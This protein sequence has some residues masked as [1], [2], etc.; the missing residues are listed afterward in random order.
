MAKLFTLEDR[1]DVI[2]GST[3]L[4]GAK[5]TQPADK[6]GLINVV[7]DFQWT[8]APRTARKDV[9]YMTLVERRITNNVLIQQA[10]Y[11]ISA[12][13]EEGSNLANTSY[14]LLKNVLNVEESDIEEDN[15][16]DRINKIR[17]LYNKNV[18]SPYSGL[19]DLDD[20]GWQ[21]VLPYF[22]N[23]NHSIRNSWGDPKE[24]GLLGGLIDTG[25]NTI[26]GVASDLNS[27]MSALG[28]ITGS[29]APQRV[30]TYI[31]RA[32]QYKFEGN[33]PTYSVQF[34][35]FN[36]VELEDVVNNWQL[37]FLLIYNTLPNRRSKTT[38]DPP[39][40]YE[41]EIPG[42][43]KSPATFINS[44]KVEFLGN[45]RI[46]DLDLTGVLGSNNTGASKFR[47]I[48]PDAYSITI[49]FEDVLPESKNFMNAMID[50]N[51]NVSVE[52][53]SPEREKYDLDSTFTKAEANDITY[54]SLSNTDRPAMSRSTQDNVFNQAVSKAG[55][56]VDKV[57]STISKPFTNRGTL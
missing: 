23:E 55:K 20:T 18:D 7:S 49:N 24:S 42:V 22:T 57:K 53:E 38:F 12:A 48:I 26:G 52:F 39:P 3:P 33:G 1:S 5:L 30:G 54:I 10:L 11:N 41:I 13:L 31:E 51:V 29:E 50:P 32:K 16:I 15:R 9:P 28:T 4:N 40:L 34:D 19:Y 25:L 27:V 6:G 47:T 8:L 35:L 43:R 17:E 46:M 14:Q 56:V 36:T 44:L 37:C 45:T 2:E 21:F